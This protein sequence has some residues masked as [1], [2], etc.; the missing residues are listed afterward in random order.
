MSAITP[1]YR[2]VQQLLQS[3]AFSID[4]YQ[5]EYKWEK[6]NIDELLSD[7]LGK[8]SNSYRPEHSTK[9]V[10]KYGEYFLGSIIVSKR[11]GKNYL[12]DGQQRV[13][14]LTLLLI[15]L[16]RIAE[17]RDLPVLQTIAPLI[18]SDNLGEP[19]FNLDIPERLP[20]IEALFKGQPFNPDG[21]DES[22]QTMYSRYGDIEQNGF[23][24]ELEEGISHFTYWL[25]TR[26]GLIEIA[27]DNDTYAY[28]IFE[29]MNDRGRTLSP[30]D[31][32]KAYLL[33]PV[34]DSDKRRASNQ[35]W[36]L[37]VLN[38][39]SW[40]QEKESERDI[41]CIKAWLRA[42]YAESTRDRKA[43]ASDKDWELIGNAF[44]RWVR[45]HHVS[46][47]LGSEIDNVRF[48]TE[49][50]P[51]FAR[52]YLRILS[53]SQKLTSGLEPIFY[54]AHNDFTWQSTVLLAPLQLS[55]DDETVRRKLAATATYLD[56]W[57][58]RRVVNYVRVGY[59]S[60]SYTMFTLCRDIR[61]KPL[62][63]LLS[64]LQKRLAEDEVTFDGHKQKPQRKGL[65]DL[66]LNQF[67]R[68][69]IY[70]LLARVT[71]FVEQGCGRTESFDK[72]VD[73]TAKN[74]FDI[75]HL[76]PDNYGAV[77]KDFESENDFEGFRNHIAS[78][79]LLPADVNRSLQDKPYKDKV[80]HYGKQNFYAA[81]L[82]ADAYNHQPKFKQFRESN[83]LPFKNCERF[84]KAEQEKRQ[85]LLVALVEVVW[86]PKRLEHYA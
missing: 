85:A 17:E 38:L 86:S 2:T 57:L 28:A 70:H 10:S 59:S 43:G 71:A 63:D 65:S 84:S 67:S 18:F 46:L 8:F 31:M 1:H 73:R 68:R 77:S 44:H 49:A 50:F 33:A 24:E 39:I 5:R 81:S 11:N 53:A 35:M 78:L 9:E 83:Q 69:Y 72:L 34:E 58:M 36:K 66:R 60:V 82:N 80:A 64:I 14:S 3:Q 26:V 23:V 20:V 15:C 6:E 52:A 29:T 48:I 45:E 62:P 76:L 16:Y 30:V 4:E 22:I 21:K 12:V 54:N 74:P 41:N 42:Q 13:T 40:G 47:G 75:E 55:D 32:L 56:I 51:F 19:K 79:L 37:N 25:L 61:R 27:T 7:L